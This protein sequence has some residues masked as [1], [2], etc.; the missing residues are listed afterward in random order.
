MAFVPRLGIPHQ[1][2]GGSHW[3][4]VGMAPLGT[5]AQPNLASTVGLAITHWLRWER[6]LLPCF[7]M[8]TQ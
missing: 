3:T 5:T 7:P 2:V 1:E 8:Y 4:G 6:D